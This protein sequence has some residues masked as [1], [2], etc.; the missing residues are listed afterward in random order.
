MKLELQNPFNLNRLEREG[1]SIRRCSEKQNKANNKLTTHSNL[2][3]N[4]VLLC[5]EKRILTI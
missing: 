3:N 4:F 2:T 1:K 5:L